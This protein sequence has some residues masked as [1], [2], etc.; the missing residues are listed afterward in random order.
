VV[1]TCHDVPF[2]STD[3]Q[4]AAPRW[5]A[6]TA[7]QYLKLSVPGLYNLAGGA[8]TSM[9]RPIGF[10]G[11]FGCARSTGTAPSARGSSSHTRTFAMD[12]R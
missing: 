8:G 2:G 9:V 5:S 4:N 11:S 6:S 10:P 7:T 3:F 1:P 12:E